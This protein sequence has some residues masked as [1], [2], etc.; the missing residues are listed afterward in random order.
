MN[1]E[2]E[3]FFVILFMANNFGFYGLMYVI[4]DD[5]SCNQYF[6]IY[7]RFFTIFPN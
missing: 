4:N 5:L 7:F 1:D 2:I 3:S 6:K